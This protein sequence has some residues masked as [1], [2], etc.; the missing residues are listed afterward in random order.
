MRENRSWLFAKY[1]AGSTLPNQ[2]T[3]QHM[4]RE[5]G[6]KVIQGWKM[7]TCVLHPSCTRPPEAAHGSSEETALKTRMPR[8]SALGLLSR[9]G[10]PLVGPFKPCSPHPCKK[11]KSDSQ[12]RCKARGFAFTPS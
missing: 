10:T 5:S 6:C 3:G 4:K 12:W 1:L 2:R 11:Q 8:D 7:Q 9:P